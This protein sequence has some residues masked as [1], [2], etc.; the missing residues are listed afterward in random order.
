[1]ADNSAV[2]ESNKQQK[3]PEKESLKSVGFF[4]QEWVK[5]GLKA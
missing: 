2:K 1:M 3:S 5:S 4:K